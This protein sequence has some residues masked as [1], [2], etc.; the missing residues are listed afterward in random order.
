MAESMSQ[1]W[2][3]YDASPQATRAAGDRQ[4]RYLEESYARQL[5]DENS[6][7][8]KMLRVP[9]VMSIIEAHAA[10]GD[11]KKA[12]AGWDEL[13]QFYSENATNI[14]RL[15]VTD[16]RGSKLLASLQEGSAIAMDRAFDRKVVN[17]PYGQMPVSEALGPDG[18]YQQAQEMELRNK[19]YSEATIKAMQ[20]GPKELVGVLNS[21]SEIPVG[22][23]KAA[24][25]VAYTNKMA[26]GAASQYRDLAHAVTTNWDNDSARI[27]ADGVSAIVSYLKDNA[28]TN[29]TATG[30][31][32][33]FVD[34]VATRLTNSTT[35]SDARTTAGQIMRSYTSI[36]NRLGGSATDGQ[37]SD[38]TARF[39]T[40]T[41]SAAISAQGDLDIEDAGTQKAIEDLAGLFAQ[42][43]RAG[44]DLLPLMSTS[45]M[46]FDREVVSYINSAKQGLPVYEGNRILQIGR[47]SARI[48]QL[49]ASQW[50]TPGQ[51]VGPGNPRDGMLTAGGVFG[52]SSDSIGIDGAAVALKRALLPIIVKKLA[53]PTVSEDQALAMVLSDATRELSPG[54]DNPEVITKVARALQTSMLIPESTAIGVARQFFANM[55]KG[56]PVRPTGIEQA[57]ADFALNEMSD[58]TEEIAAART[59]AQ[60]WYAANMGPNSKGYEQALR[61]WMATLLDEITG[62][63]ATKEGTTQAQLMF[64]SALQDIAAA[65]E[66]GLPVDALIKDRLNHGQFYYIAGFRDAN[67]KTYQSLQDIM[68][69]FPKLDLKKNP[70]LLNQFSPVIATAFGNLDHVT[71]DIPNYT[72]LGSTVL[73]T[74]GRG[75]YTSNRQL[76]KAGQ[77][78]LRKL[79]QTQ[80]AQLA[81]QMA[82]QIEAGN[83]P[84]E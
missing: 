65:A 64:Q 55:T 83:T 37:I 5:Q 48:N 66:K 62:F 2:G 1:Y 36:L 82:K 16:P 42:S 24:E 22:N 8:S 78:A 40:K 57:I 3:L 68:S 10:A 18:A 21:L 44:I 38:S 72:P 69:A 19:N 50:I 59:A 32:R 28:M 27:G 80:Q 25:R 11:M 67:G 46:D 34:M 60:K 14:A 20:E 33:T 47:A 4:A 51:P 26:M 30:L 7:A 49:I 17:T 35:A 70:Q 53:D 31:Y 84:E 23:V 39:L 12:K 54:E 29:G 52:A 76:Y 58:D 63:G 81:K 74:F 79:Y 56:G 77:A 13:N 61:P 15:Y 9:Q 71:Q 6:F 73:P 41:L 75:S 43:S 45:G